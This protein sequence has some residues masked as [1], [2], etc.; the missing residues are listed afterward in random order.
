MQ[1]INAEVFLAS[2]TAQITFLEQEA[3]D[4]KDNPAVF[5][6]LK[7]TILALHAVERAAEGATIRVGETY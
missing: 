7:S 5:A 3:I 6:Y 4:S 1:V 2:L